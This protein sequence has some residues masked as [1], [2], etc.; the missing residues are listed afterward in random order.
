ML[1]SAL[2]RELK[3]LIAATADQE[4]RGCQPASRIADMNVQESRK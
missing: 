2:A 4:L 1:T 3:P